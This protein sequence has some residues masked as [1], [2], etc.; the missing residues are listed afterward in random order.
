MSEKP[1]TIIRAPRTSE[2]PYFVTSRA[3]AQ[4][5]RLS[6]DSRGI[7]WY[8]L[9]KPDDWEIRP[10]TLELDLPGGAKCGRDKV[11]RLLKELRSAGY[12]TFEQENIKGV[13]QTGYYQLHEVP[14]TANPVTVQPQ[15]ANP[16]TA[17]GEKPQTAKPES[18]SSGYIHNKENTHNKELRNKKEN[19]AR[20]KKSSDK[21]KTQGDKLPKP[22]GKKTPPPQPPA[23]KRKRKTE[24]EKWLERAAAARPMVDALLRQFEAAYDPVMFKSLEEYCTQTMLEKYVPV[25]EELIRI[26]CQPE[27]VAEIYSMLQPFYNK[28]GWKVGLKTISDKYQDWKAWKAK[29]AQPKQRPAAPGKFPPVVQNGRP[30]REQA[31]ATLA[32][33]R[34][35]RVK[36]SA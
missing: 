22:R 26:G 25:A 24:M 10:E 31:A 23:P 12:L 9:S 27:N 34:A 16:V 15:T 35:A 5:K 19:P 32:Q 1:I 7:L 2:R 18:G 17:Q 4:D 6:W 30:S 20:V 11:Q 33:L 8:L 14:Q 29:Q 3:A 36:Q 28:K 13:F 21:S